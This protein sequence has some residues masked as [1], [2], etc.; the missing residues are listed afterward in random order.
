MK[1][2]LNQIEEINP[3][4]NAI[5]LLRDKEE[6]LQE[7]RD[8]D[9]APRKGWL[10]GIP[11][12]VKDISNTKGIATTMGGSRLSKNF[13]PNFDDPFVR[14]MKRAGAIIIGKTNTPENGLGSHT[15]NERWGTTKNPFNLKKSAGG[16]SGGAGVAVSTR[17]LVLADGTD[18]MGSLRNPAGWNAI[19]SHRPTAGRIRGS[20]ASSKNPLP[21]PTSTVGPMARTPIDCAML[22]ETM[23][24]GDFNASSVWN[25]EESRKSIRIGWLGD[26]GGRLPMEN[27][28][29]ELCLGA[30]RELE[31]HGDATVEDISHEIF[32]FEDLW[33]NWN[34]VRFAT[35]AAL[36]SE[37]FNMDV[38]LGNNSPIK[39][40]LKWEIEQGMQVTED[41]LL[42]AKR[43]GISYAKA[44]DE[45]FDRYDVLALPSSQVFPF[46]QEWKWPKEIEAQPMDTY[47]R[48]MAVC[49]P[50]TFGGLPCSTIPAGFGDTGL[51]TGIQLFGRRHED[52][53]TL[54]LADA[55]HELVDWPS[56]VAFEPKEDVILSWTK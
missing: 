36:F 51:P 14:N 53:Q 2:T 33:E 3:R 23:S 39:E 10:H 18:M 12:A 22:L 30:L 35:V 50:V 47:H 56:R 21:Y 43:I 40:E 42:E 27:G 7:A 31:E 44:L 9:M 29:L 4:C 34:R 24:D 28:V 32:P 37:T 25:V 5:I 19:Y 11:I 8:A 41:D 55:Y 38:I 20:K 16:S 13:V 45:V 15:Y 48:W 1:A 46:P 26:W 6:L 49:V 17:M 52:A 54:R